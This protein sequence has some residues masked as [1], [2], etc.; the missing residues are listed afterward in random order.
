[1]TDVEV[2][3]T[4]GGGLRFTGHAAVFNSP[5]DLGPFREQV[6][7]GA[8][9]ATIRP[10]RS[11]V[12]FLYNH[13]PDSVMARTTNGTLHL[14]EDAIGLLAE[15]DLDPSDVDVQRLV[16]K[17]RSGNVSQ[18]S[19]GFRVVKDEWEEDG[20]DGRELRT[21]KEVQLF[22]VSAVT[23]PAY[24]DTDAALASMARGTVAVAESRGMSADTAQVADAIRDSMTSPHEEGTEDPPA[25]RQEQTN[26]DDPHPDTSPVPST[27]RSHL[28]SRIAYL[29]TTL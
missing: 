9:K 1:M 23:F 24:D 6:A 12:R 15:A 2:R 4:D 13:E 20:D 14:R 22:D 11:D 27:S 28:Q 19:F 17:L 18:M 26:E 21:L 29:E 10:E 7:P 3:E 5:T 8:F 16:P 25:V